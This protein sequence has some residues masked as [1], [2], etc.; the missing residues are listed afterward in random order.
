MPTPVRRLA[1]TDR[2]VANSFTQPCRKDT[3]FGA[4]ITDEATAYKAFRAAV[5]KRIQLRAVRFEFCPE[6]TAKIRRMGYAIHEVPIG[7]SARSVLQGKKIGYRDGFEAFWTLVKY[8]CASRRSFITD[9][10]VTA[11]TGEAAPSVA[12]G[13]RGPQSGSGAP[14][15]NRAAG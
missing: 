5:I 8:R 14:G 6:V 9:A 1:L 3:L 7:Y 4:R 10:G 2:P 15:R 12:A 13:A 11:V